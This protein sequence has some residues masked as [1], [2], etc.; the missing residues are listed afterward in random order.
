[1]TSSVDTVVSEGTARQ[2]SGGLQRWLWPLAGIA[3]VIV[4]ELTAN[5]SLSAF[6]FCLRFG[7]ADFR[8]VHWISNHDPHRGRRHALYCFH[9]AIG[10]L[11]IVLG[12]IVV[13]VL[14]TA[15]LLNLQNEMGPV[16]LEA[17]GTAVMTAAGGLV[18]ALL[19]TLAGLFAA[20]DSSTPLWIDRQLHRNASGFYPPR[21]FSGVN[22]LGS[23]ISALAFLTFLV[24][25]FSLS[26][27]GIKLLTWAGASPELLP[28]AIAA[29]AA[30]AIY[31]A[32]LIQQCGNRISAESPQDCWPEL[33]FYDV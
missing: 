25:L 2:A 31:A 17:A 28:L 10:A 16:K 15:L 26:A 18:V 32:I 12:G 1:M 9:A 27:V 6:V 11:K 14:L 33:E 19:M 20:I 29:A 30:G 22:E 13:A 24:A 21:Q 7:W 23:L 8:T 4:F 5:L 3:A